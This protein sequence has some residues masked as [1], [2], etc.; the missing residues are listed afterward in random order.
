S[1]GDVNES[2]RQRDGLRRTEECRV[3]CD[4]VGSKTGIGVDNRLAKRAGPAV[5][6]IQYDESG[7]L[8]FISAN[9]RGSANDAKEANAALIVDEA[10]GVG[11]G[12]D[13]RAAGQKSVSLR[14]SA[15]IGEGAKLGVEWDRLGA[16]LIVRSREGEIAFVGGA[17]EIVV[18]ANRR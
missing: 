13:R 3:K 7:S 8:T 9:V 18:P 1:V 5:I 14:R 6:R 4:Y 2:A 16:S 11:A 15:I 10:G 17:N 12:V